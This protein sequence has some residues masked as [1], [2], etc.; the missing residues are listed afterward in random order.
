MR[1]PFVTGQYERDARLMKR[2]GRDLSKL[3]AV[4]DAIVRGERLPDN[5]RDH[6]L[7]GEW[8]GRRECHVE[9]DWLLIYLLRDD[10]EVVF[11]RTGRHT[12]LFE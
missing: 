9:P 12:D 6:H 3:R 7:K 10:D 1:R 2:R 11:E 4:M 8:G 5:L